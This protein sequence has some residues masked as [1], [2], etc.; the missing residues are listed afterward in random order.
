MSYY[1]PVPAE[2]TTRIPEGYCTRED[3]LETATECAQ[4]YF[5]GWAEVDNKD[6]SVKAADTA[7][8]AANMLVQSGIVGDKVRAFISGHANV[9]P[10]PTTGS[11]GADTCVINVQA[12]AGT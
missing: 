7:I 11:T 3:F 9:V 5:A 6:A 2:S 4:T 12:V 1:F 10:G 8:Q